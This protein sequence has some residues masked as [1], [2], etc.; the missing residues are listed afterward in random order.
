[1]FKDKNI[2]KLDSKNLQKFRNN[3]IGFVFQ[4]HHLMQNLLH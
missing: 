2:T 3:N 1:M 4:F